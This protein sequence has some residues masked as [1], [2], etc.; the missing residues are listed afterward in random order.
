[1]NHKTRKTLTENNIIGNCI[2]FFFAGFE[3]T[4]STI[5]HCLYEMAKYPETQQRLY[6]DLNEA[7]QGKSGDDFYETVF[8]HVPYLQAVVNE[9][10]RLYPPVTELTRRVFS[11]SVK[12]GGIQLKKDMTIIIPSYAIHHCADYYSNPEKFDPTRFLPENKHLLVPNTFMPFG[13]GPRNCMGMRFALNEVKLCVARLA[14]K[15]RFKM[16]SKTPDKL[17]FAKRSFN[18]LRSEQFQIQVCAR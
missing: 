11:D 18:L 12:V 17:S 3:T 4:S 13:M 2:F 7:V 6:E 14:L 8:H 9:T 10:L 15:Y 16:T 5:S 1:M